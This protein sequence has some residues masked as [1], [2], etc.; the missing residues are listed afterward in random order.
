MKK[1]LLLLGLALWCSTAFAEHSQNLSQEIP[2]GQSRHITA[3]DHITLSPG[4]LAM[5][6]D[7]NEI[8]LEIDDFDTSPPEAGITGGPNPGDDGVVG[9]LNGSIDVSALGAATYSIPIQ[10][11]QGLGGL[12]PQLSLYYNNQQRNG[13][14]GWDWDISGISTITRIGGTLYHDG[15]VS[16]VNYTTDRFCLDGQR[17]LRVRGGAY[18]E[19]YTSYRTEQD[20]M[21]KIISFW[22]NGIN[23]PAYFKVWTADGKILLYG[24]S[25]DSKALV[26]ADHHVNSWLLK[27]IEDLYGNKIT[28]HYQNDAE[29]YRLSRIEYSGND[30]DDLD[31]AFTVLFSYGSRDDIDLSYHGDCLL[32]KDALLY[33]ISVKNGNHTMYTYDFDYHQPDPQHGYPYPRLKSIGFSVS[34]KHF[35][36]TTIEWGENNYETAISSS[37][38]YVHTST[39]NSAFANAVKFSGDF[40]GDGYTDVLAIRPNPDGTYNAQA[41]LFLNKGLSGKLD[42]DYVRSFT[43]NDLIN[44]VYVADFNGDGRDDILLTYRE[45]RSFPV[46]D[47]INLTAYLSQESNSNN[48]I[49]NPQELPP[50]YIHNDL[51]ESLLI[52]DFLGEGRQAILIQALENNK[53][54]QE[55]SV[56]IRYDDTENQ[57]QQNIFND[58]LDGTVFYPA[59]YDGDGVTEI[60]YKHNEVTVLEK[61]SI[62]DG[63]PHF[64]ELFHGLPREW[65]DCFPG[66]FNGDGVTDVLLY[67]PNRTPHWSITLFA[68]KG[69][70]AIQYHL[71]SFPYDS[72]GDYHFTL[73]NPHETDHFIKVGDFDGNGCADLILKEGIT[74]HL[75]LGPLHTDPSGMPF[76]DHRQFSDQVFHFFSN[77]DLCIGNFLG[78]DNLSF[79]GNYTLS[80]LPSISPRYEVKRIT[81]GM[82]RS[83]CFQYDYLMGN[84]RNPSEDDFYYLHSYVSQPSQQIF[85]AALPLRAL[86]RVTTYNIQDKP[87]TVECH[88]EG[89]LLHK[90]GKGFLGFSQTAQKD[91]CD[92]QLQKR[93]VRHFDVDLY[94]NHV[95]NPVL[96]YE[97]LFNKDGQRI[98]ETWYANKIYFNEDNEKVY[99]PIADKTISEYDFDHPENLIKKEIHETVVSTH[100]EDNYRYKNILSVMMTKKG[101][102]D[103]PNVTLADACDFRSTTEYTYEDD[104]TGYWLV[105]RPKTI[106][107][108]LQ[109]QGDYDDIIHHRIINYN[110]QKPFQVKTVTEMPND[111]SDD[112][113]RLTKKTEYL[114]DLT[115]NITRQTV[116]APHDELPPRMESFDYGRTYGRR[117][118]T[119]HTNAAGQETI[120]EYDP[121]YGHRTLMTDCNGQETRYEQDP[122]GVTINTVYPDGSTSC[123]AVRWGHGGYY[124]WEKRSGQATKITDHALTGEVTAQKRYSLNGEVVESTMEYDHYGRK[125]KE[126]RPSMNGRANQSITFSY[127][128]YHRVNAISHSDGTYETISYDGPRS[129]ASFIGQDGSRQTESKTVNAMGWVVRSTDAD[130]VSVIYDYYPDGKPRW[131]QIEAMEETK[132]EMAYDGLGNRCSLYDPD[133]GTTTDLYNVFGEW[134]RNTT[135]VAVTEIEY[136]PLGNKTSQNV[137]DPISGQSHLTRWIYSTTKGSIGLLKRIESEQ[138]VITYDYDNLLRLKTAT[139][140]R[141]G[142]LYKTTYTYD[143]ASRTTGITYPSGYTTRY[144]YT[145]EGQLRKVTD[146][147]EG[148]LWKT[149]EANAMGI[150]TKFVT[151]NG[152]ASTYDFDERNKLSAIRTT[153][154]DEVIQDYSYAYDEFSNMTDRTDHRYGLHEHFTFDDLNRLTGATDADGES[155][156]TYDPLGRMLSKTRGGQLVFDNANYEGPKPHAIK[157]AH[158]QEGSFPQSRMD[159]D[160]TN[161]GM[162]SSIREGNN[163]IN[164]KYGYDHQRIHCSEILNG[165]IREKTYVGNCEFITQEGNGTITRTFLNGPVGVFAVAETL[166][167]HTTIHYVHKDHLGSWTTISDSKGKIE[168]ENRFDA[169][170]LCQ[171]NDELMFERGFTG[172]EHIKGVHLINMNG[173][174]YDPLTSSMLSP[175]RFVQ[176]PDFT[177][178]F[179]R[180]TYC[181]NNPLTYVDPDGN[182]F[183]ETA[184]IFYVLFFTDMGYELQKELLP[185][186]L[187]VDLHLSTQQIGIGLDASAGIPK[188]YSL[189]VRFHG[190]ITY[191]WNFYDH[192]Y[193]GWE[194]RTGTELCFGNILG[195]SGTTYYYGGKKQSTN[196]LYIGN[197]AWHVEYENDFMFHITDDILGFTHADNGD[198]YRTAAAKVRI[199]FTHVGVNLFTGDPGLDDADRQTAID[200]T[201]HKNTY[202]IGKNGEDPDEYRAGVLYAGWGPVKMGVNSEKVRDALQNRFAHSFLRGDRVPYFKMLDRPTQAYFYFG[203]GT[204]NS[205]W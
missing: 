180:Y 29:A 129:T 178:N 58:H 25:D 199:G 137:I 93:S 15:Y 140:D 165:K 168:Q 88:Y 150:P 201:N 104:A 164:Y 205:L 194:F 119:T 102:T 195:I 157:S 171:N 182:S 85:T 109:R 13:V 143:K 158:T 112:N 174:V 84:P 62:T 91:Y 130:S 186:A 90:Q 173:R 146:A 75:Y 27:S 5:P 159:I 96:L 101:V 69:I 162:V 114:Y 181:L 188:Q 204:G 43:L 120:F 172:H 59:D 175:D 48:L 196:T 132:I 71:P 20:Q 136:D 38:I 4:F 1:Q 57:F 127:D 35:N 197:K 107:E 193:S 166:N 24:S 72:P 8:L 103:N 28:Y 89:V 64:I 113:D 176:M 138:Q 198:R 153:H 22:D 23:G 86:K 145:S 80:H 152:F 44:W 79:L 111:G 16:A 66:D 100:N 77:M 179:N 99:V 110:P 50:F 30:N 3:S 94:N 203:S 83:V 106:T 191:Y 189:S 108:T 183:I 37:S 2:P 167:G 177:Q 139:E 121:V 45:R 126:T 190:G 19:N 11:P 116:S 33:H 56:I 9:A 47:K 39:Y 52:G 65:D 133:Y 40:N 55:Q 53:S 51:L 170:G 187:H 81:D 10:L 31:P 117:L 151:G 7:S 67:N 17:L 21:S 202:I 60:L 105:N 49:F 92:N 192:S 149:M 154:G 184:L 135:P 122:L 78:E 73:D 68:Q 97:E 125:K 98:G 142:D 42:F 46:P 61:L 95:I 87:V 160:Y 63:T 200:P 41:R 115:G 18:G 144:H 131:T 6:S 163:E 161:D 147:N 74:T 123:Q 134:I 169:W 118:L 128:M 26:S 14:L 32:K 70:G 155:L 156:Y 76:T 12:T 54:Q 36:P 82:D 34:D 141:M 148:L 185:I 124:I